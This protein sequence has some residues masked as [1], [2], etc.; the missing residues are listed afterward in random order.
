MYVLTVGSLY[1]LFY[2]KY[3]HQII[4]WYN[5][6]L[7]AP[8]LYANQ[9]EGTACLSTTNPKD[10]VLKGR[11]RTSERIERSAP[12]PLG[13]TTLGRD[14]QK[15]NQSWPF[16]EWW[17]S[18]SLLKTAETKTHVS[19]VVLEPQFFL[20]RAVIFSSSLPFLLYK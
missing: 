12:R 1:Y 14:A 18:D 4:I 8:L 13:E 7:H 16:G 20:I 11:S 17:C 19:S 10:K 2:S 5:R 3:I 6:Y 15:P 9:E